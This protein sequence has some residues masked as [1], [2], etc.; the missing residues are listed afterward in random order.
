MQ[1][2]FFNIKNTFPNQVYQFNI[3]NLIKPDSL[4]NHGMKPLVYS[5]LEY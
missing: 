4:Y 5:E 2:Y 3:I 1:W